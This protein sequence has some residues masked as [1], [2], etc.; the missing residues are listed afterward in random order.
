MVSRILLAFLAL[1]GLALAGCGGYGT[2]EQGRVIHYDKDKKIVTFLPNNE[3][4]PQKAPNYRLPVHVFAMPTDPGEMGRE[5][6]SGQ[7]RVNVDTAKKIISMYNPEKNVIEDIP[8]EL[9]ENTTGVELRRRHPLVWDPATR[10]ARPFPQVNAEKKTVTV[11]SARQSQVTVLKLSDADFTRY[12]GDQWG[13]GDEVRIYYKEAGKMTAESP[14]KS[15]R[16]MNV[17]QTDIMRRR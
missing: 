13:A 6:K 15:L 1:A 4:N 7:L 5:P 14:G 2:V 12:K 9:V 10:R 16:F 11:Y 8:F 3:D 17:T